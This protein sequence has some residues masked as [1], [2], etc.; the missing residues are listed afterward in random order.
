MKVYNMNYNKSLKIY[1][2]NKEL[3]EIKQCYKNI[4]NLISRY[5]LSNKWKICYGYLKIMDNL[6]CRH[7]FILE[8]DKIIDPTYFL[9]NKDKNAEYTI[10]KTFNDFDEYIEA[11]EGNDLF[12]DLEVFLINE[13]RE[14][15]R[16]ML[17]HGQICIT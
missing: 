6:W 17:E 15:K 11:I 16:E 4:F 14:L 7:C 5:G 13:D 1:N 8:N 10:F 3:F 9:A 2:K 12:V